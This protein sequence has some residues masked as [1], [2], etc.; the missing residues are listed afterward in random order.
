M[1]CRRRSD[2]DEGEAMPRLSIVIPVRNEADNIVGLVEGIDRAL[3]AFAPIEIIVVDDGSSDDS[4]AR[5]TRHARSMPHLRLM[6]HAVATA[7]MLCMVGT[8]GGAGGKPRPRQV[9]QLRQH[10]P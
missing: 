10:A 9:F 1:S 2:R 4:V 7:N 6:R 5:L 3:A 8:T